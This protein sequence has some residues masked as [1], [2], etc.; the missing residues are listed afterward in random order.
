MPPLAPAWHDG[1]FLV[2]RDALD[3]SQTGHPSVLRRND[4]LLSIHEHGLCFILKDAAYDS[5]ESEK[6]RL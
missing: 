4:G 6:H 1:V 5:H 2:P 3:V